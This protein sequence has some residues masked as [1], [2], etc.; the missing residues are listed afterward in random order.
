[1]LRQKRGYFRVSY[2][3]VMVLIL[4][5]VIVF[6][7]NPAYNG[8]I[9]KEDSL[10][11]NET[12]NQNS[13]LENFNFNNFYALIPATSKVFLIILWSA[14]GFIILMFAIGRVFLN[15]EE[16]PEEIDLSSV[17]KKSN[18]D[19][20][21]LYLL[22]KDKKEMSISLISKIFNINEETAEGWCRIL[23]SGK[24]ALIDYNAAGREVIRL[25]EE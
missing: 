9:I 15:K 23:E 18:T 2:L 11:N 13:S 21:A 12:Q 17:L 24:L 20:D 25:N 4:S 7:D 8:F 19:L 3:V 22:L 1:M 10:N 16:M 6:K 5:L 14:L